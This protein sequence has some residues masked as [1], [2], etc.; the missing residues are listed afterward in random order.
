MWSLAIKLKTCK[1]PCVIRRRSANSAARSNCGVSTN[2]KNV[3]IA[4]E[5]KCVVPHRAIGPHLWKPWKTTCESITPDHRKV[6]QKMPASLT[7]ERAERK[8]SFVKLW[9]IRVK[10]GLSVDSKPALAIRG[11]LEGRRHRS[12]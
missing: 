8:N 3:V 6:A 1:Y 2:R 12:R 5:S 11:G 9:I 10:W 4:A 7:S